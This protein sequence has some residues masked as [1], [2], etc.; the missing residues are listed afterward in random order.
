MRHRLP[1]LLAGALFGLV[2]CGGDEHAPSPPV[3]PAPVIPPIAGPTVAEQAG[4]SRL[5]TTI[6]DMEITAREVEHLV[7]AYTAPVRTA[8]LH[9]YDRA[10]VVTE[11]RHAL[12]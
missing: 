3:P 5:A 2:A 6:V 9:V 11:P 7:V 1:G 10:V 12:L 4:R 8:H